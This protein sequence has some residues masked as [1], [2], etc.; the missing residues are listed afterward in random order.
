MYRLI[1]PLT[2]EETE[3]VA[4]LV[5]MAAMEA[6]AELERAKGRPE[7]E[8]TWVNCVRELGLLP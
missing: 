8:L 4:Q 5:E 6:W 3:V 2:T 7:S 1:A